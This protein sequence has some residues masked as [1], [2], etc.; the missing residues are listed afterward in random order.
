MENQSVEDREKKQIQKEEKEEKIGFFEI[1]KQSF[2]PKVYKEVMDRYSFGKIFKYFLLFL[3]LVALFSTVKYFSFFFELRGEL[4]NWVETDFSDFI[5]ENIP[6]SLKIENGEVWCSEEQPFVRSFEFEEERNG[7]KKESYFIID[8]TG[9]IE[10]IGEREGMLITK[11]KITIRSEE[12]SGHFKEE[13]FDIS[14]IE[15][16]E[17]RKGNISRGEFLVLLTENKNISITQEKLERWS[18]NLILIITPFILVFGFIFL[19]I[20]KLF[21]VLFFSLFSLILNAIL[22][23]NLKYRQLFAIGIL[24]LIP[25]TLIGI[26]VSLFAA[27]FPF[28]WVIYLVFLTFAIMSYKKSHKEEAEKEN[29]KTA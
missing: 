6:E 11:N 26:L 25:V 21:Y 4:V 2:N 22:K 12:Y 29:L 5:E 28:L 14:E 19:I 20:G 10:E 16:F 27:G 7:E 13:D 9:E 24:A 1:L 8:T 3:F 15:Y 18:R 23:T 17:I